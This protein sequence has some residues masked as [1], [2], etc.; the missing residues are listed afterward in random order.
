MIN[1]N[2]L[3]FLKKCGLHLTAINPETKKPVDKSGYGKWVEW[4]PDEIIKH[5]KQRAGF[6]HD[7]FNDHEDFCFLDVD[8]DDKS[9]IANQLMHQLPVTLTLGKK[10]NGSATIET[11]ATFKIPKELKPKKNFELFDSKGNKIIEVLRSTCTWALGHNRHIIRKKDPIMLDAD[12]IL[13]LFKQLKIINLI[14]ELIK[15]WPKE[16]KR[17]EAYLRLNGALTRGTDLTTLEKEN[18]TETLCELTNDP[19]V[20]NRRDKVKYQEKQFKENPEQVAGIK[21]LCAALNIPTLKSFDYL[22]REEEK[23]TYKIKYSN[24]DTFMT[25]HFPEPQ[26]LIDP[27]VR[28]QSITAIVGEVG[29]GKTHLGLRLAAGVACGCGFMGMPS[30]NGPRPV[31]Y[32]EGELPSWDIKSRIADIKKDFAK[33]GIK[34]DSDY[35]NLATVQQQS[36]YG[37]PL[38]HKEGGM[39]SVEEV[40]EEISKRTGKKVY[41]HLDNISSLCSGI[42]ENKAEAWAP[43]MAHFIRLKN[44][45]HTITYHHHLNHQKYAS[46]ST[47]QSRGIQMTIRLRKPDSKHRIPMKGEK[48]MQAVVDFPKWTL[49]DNSK[50][51]QE[52]ILTCDEDQ[53]WKKYPMLEENELKIIKFHEEGLSVQ[54]MEEEMDIKE[55]TIYRKLKR[56]K[57]M[58]VIKDEKKSSK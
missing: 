35:F 50:H 27:F 34:W 58:G 33:R 8:F 2:D 18:I 45:G 3:T 46:G 14:T 38:L 30:V 15:N 21:S 13:N 43:L 40:M 16:G 25:T 5:N 24:L 4:E 20:K 39:E 48:A 11:H 37:F 28:E 52:H 53:N 41:T 7:R 44:K 10:P 6:Y 12:G 9:L 17:D 1:I 26:Y 22:K 49:H 32:I 29:V 54:E 19:E 31:L 47:M 55:K 36:D 51:A 57:D 23:K 56:L 42:E